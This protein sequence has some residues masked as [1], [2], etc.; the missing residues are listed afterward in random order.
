[1]TKSSQREAE[2]QLNEKHGKKTARR[3][4]TKTSDRKGRGGEPHKAER[5]PLEI[6]ISRYLSTIKPPAEKGTK[7]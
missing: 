3:I 7:R 2:I 1:M 5:P 4:S 6:E